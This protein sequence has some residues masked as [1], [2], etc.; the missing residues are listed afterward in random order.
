MEHLTS[1]TIATNNAPT[2]RFTMHVTYYHF[3]DSYNMNSNDIE[4]CNISILH[5]GELYIVTDKSVV[6]LHALHAAKYI[7]DTLTHYD[8]ATNSYSIKNGNFDQ[9]N[10]CQ[11]I[12]NSK[13]KFTTQ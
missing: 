7:N 13:E 9:K 2:N 10:H 6:T 5:N 3:K 12:T 11:Y 4:L 1:K 8:R